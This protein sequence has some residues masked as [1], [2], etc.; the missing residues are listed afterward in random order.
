MANRWNNENS[1]RLSFL[2][3][4]ITADDDYSHDFK[5]FLLL[6]RKVMT[7]LDSILKSR[8]IA[9]KVCLVK[10]MAFPVVMYGC[11][12][13]T[14]KKA[15]HQRIYT[16]EHDVGGDSWESLELQGDQPV[17]PKGNQS[18]IF[19]GRNDAETE[20]PI[21]WQSDSKNWLIGKHPDAGKDWRQEEK[22]TTVMRWLDGIMSLCKL[23][24]LVMDREA[25]PSVVNWFAKS[26]PLLCN[27][28]ELTR[29]AAA[30]AKLAST[31]S[32]PL[33]EIQCWILSLWP[34]YF[35]QFIN[36]Q[37]CFIGRF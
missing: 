24:K 27:S 20:A 23:C 31:K 28:T 18:W 37:P 26:Q 15:E 5:R 6:G 19:I 21:L 33:R 30:N 2:G 29:K 12:I 13:W 36:T 32:S 34:K 1:D 35:G 3:S 17:N 16:F 25:W 8:D 4:K 7:K 14:I 10:A 22:G 9:D 11:E